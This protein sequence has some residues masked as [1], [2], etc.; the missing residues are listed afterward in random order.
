MELL[1]LIPVALTF[2]LGCVWAWQLVRRWD[3]PPDGWSES[4]AAYGSL[5]SLPPLALWRF[6]I[7]SGVLA[8]L[9]AVAGVCWR[10]AA[11]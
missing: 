5:G 3:C 9:I 2:A 4:M 7:V 1:L 11:G 6:G 8:A 10:V